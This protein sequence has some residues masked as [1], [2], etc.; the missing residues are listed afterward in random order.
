MVDLIK[1][2]GLGLRGF[3]ATHPS[4]AFLSPLYCI[5]VYCPEQ[6]KT[7]GAWSYDLLHP[8]TLHLKPDTRTSTPAHVGFVMYVKR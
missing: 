4:E 3:N 7:L 8:F 5:Y 2:S 1:V 6:L